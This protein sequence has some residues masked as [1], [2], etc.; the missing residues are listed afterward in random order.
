MN[1]LHVAFI[2]SYV[3]SALTKNTLFNIILPYPVF[4]QVIFHHLFHSVT[5]KL[6]KYLTFPPNKSVITKLLYINLTFK[7]IYMHPK[8]IKFSI[9]VFKAVR[10]AT[11]R[12][13]C[14]YFALEGRNGLSN[15]LSVSSS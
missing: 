10:G 12:V 6:V 13:H 14:E 9:T 7:L 3:F 11:P 2:L 15:T 8:C 1:N 5:K 4:P